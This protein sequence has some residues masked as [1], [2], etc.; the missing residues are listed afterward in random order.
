MAVNI[1][2]KLV[3]WLTS[4]GSEFICEKIR[5][6]IPLIRIASAIKYLFAFA[7]A[8][9]LISLIRTNTRKYG[10]ENSNATITDFCED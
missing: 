9:I 2:N 1:N 8:A 10:A 5:K 4:S 6:V 7:N 3:R